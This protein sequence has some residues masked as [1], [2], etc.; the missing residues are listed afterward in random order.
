MVNFY[1]YEHYKKLLRTVPQLQS[2]KDNVSADLC[3]HFVGGGLA[4][5]TAATST[6][7]YPL[8]VVVVQTFICISN[9]PKYI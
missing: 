4:D 6:S 2:N 5:I 1:S 3:I 7:T 8:L 9:M